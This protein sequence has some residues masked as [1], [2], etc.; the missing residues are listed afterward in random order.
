MR[1]PDESPVPIIDP[2]SQLHPGSAAIEVPLA[3]DALRDDESLAA[4]PSSNVV[5]HLFHKGADF[6]E[7]EEIASDLGQWLANLDH[8]HIERAGIPL[9]PETPNEVFDM[10]SEHSDRIF[11]TLRA[12]PHE[13]IRGIRRTEELCRTYPFIRSLSITPHFLHPTI[14]PN[15]KEYYPVYAKCIELNM[16]VFINVGFPGPRVLAFSQDPMHLDEVCWFFPELRVV[17]RHGGEPWEDVCVKLMLR[18]PNLY[19][20]TTAFAP[21]YYPKAIID[22]ANTRVRQSHLGWIL[23]DPSIRT[24][25]RGAL[26]AVVEGFGLAEV[27]TRESANGIRSRLKRR[28]GTITNRTA[29]RR[30]RGRL[31]VT[32]IRLLT[33]GE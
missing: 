17:M 33:I 16:A 22:Y 12:N 18:W 10:L 19:F 2:F 29:E 30:F 3:R 14:P 31:R 25:L 5:G 26:G 28:R 11:V 8:F 13:G 32:S 27:P 21:K 7:R 24:D 15:S 9:A 1:L 4:W 23:A 20:A 6:L